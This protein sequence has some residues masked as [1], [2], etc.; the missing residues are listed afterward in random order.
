MAEINAA[1]KKATKRLNTTLDSSM[2][3]LS[4]EPP[5]LSTFTQKEEVFE[6][7]NHDEPSLETSIKQALQTQ[8]DHEMLYSQLGPLGQ[9]YVSALLGGNRRN[10]IDHVRC[11]SQRQM[12]DDLIS[13]KMIP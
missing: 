3:S 12:F 8:E 6:T 4:I 13:I 7:K 5:E 10:E 2:L 11:V 9:K 1:A